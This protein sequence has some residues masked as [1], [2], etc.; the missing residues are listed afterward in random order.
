MSKPSRKV[1]A[2][3]AA[4]LTL[5]IVLV[6][7]IVA[8]PTLHADRI[9]PGVSVRDIE[10]GNLTVDEATTTLT[11]RLSTP[12]MPAIKLQGSDRSW[13]LDWADVGREYAWDETAA[14]AYEA[15]RR[16]PWH[17]RVLSAWRIRFYGLTIEPQVDPADPS[18]VR[19][20][21]DTIAP[22]VHVPPTEAVLHISPSGATCVPGKPGRALNVEATAQRVM[23][24]LAKGVAEVE[25][26]MLALAPAL[27]EPEP[28]CTQAQ[29][30]L[31]Q[32]FTVIADDPLT[33]HQARYQVPTEQL[34]TWLRVTAANH[35]VLLEVNEPAVEAWL[36]GVAP[37]LGPERILDL[38]ETLRRTLAALRD[39]EHQARSAI[40][41]PKTS[42]VV[43]P[44]DTLFDIAYSHGF[45]Q[46][47]LEEANP[48]VEPGELLIGME[49]TIPSIDVLFPEPL[50]P[51]KRI[52][53]DLPEQRLR[54]YE[55]DEVVYDFT[56]SSGM[57]STPTIAGQFQ[58]LFKEPQAYAQRWSLE[59][60]YFIAIYY[61]GPDFANGIHE[62]PIRSNGQRLWASVLGWPA[63]Y[64]CIIL[65]V[66]DAEKLY[67]WAPVGTLVRIEGVAPGTPAYVPRP[68]QDT[69]QE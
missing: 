57:T 67:H 42:Y 41:H 34:V 31:S 18:R 35:H 53:I 43:E 2:G 47:R 25:T 62:L 38:D 29:S 33:T 1:I 20:V 22:Q 30:L 69:L 58:V 48:D 7:T 46:W 24:A 59:M 5:C 52:E 54:A 27:S 19:A 55:N 6:G 36:R 21:L 66:G 8:Y 61:E 50:V 15:G 26:V 4:V 56:C 9:Y 14:A 45:P 68:D 65:D 51:D 23:D 40:R 63:S 32:P 60:P 16:G 39:G 28:G 3:L 13:Q 64:G 11:N 12:S 44:G 37:Q 49:L 10:L 17:E